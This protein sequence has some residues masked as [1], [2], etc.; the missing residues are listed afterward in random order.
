MLSD[1]NREVRHE[2]RRRTACAPTVAYWASND[3]T[4]TP[5][6]GTRDL[7][8]VTDPITTRSPPTKAPGSPGDASD[9]NAATHC[10]PRCSPS[11]YNP[12]G[13]PTT[14][15]APLTAELRGL[16]PDAVTAGQMTYDLR[17]LR[18][19]ASSA[20]SR[21]RTATGSPT[22]DYTPPYSSPAST[23]D[24][25]PSAWPSTPTPPCRARSAQPPPHT[26]PRSTTSLPQPVSPHD[27]PNPTHLS[28]NPTQNYGSA[29][30]SPLD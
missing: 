27:Q 2:V 14:T 15:Y 4:T 20:R 9:S 28:T 24:Y 29:A 3:S 7:H 17:R 30:C 16:P 5:I 19:H 26:G 13:S 11:D 12:A 18:T 23:I 6:T 1:R 21:T 22:T 8:T 10:C 25:Y